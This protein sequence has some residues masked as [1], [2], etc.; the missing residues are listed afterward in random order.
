MQ[1]TTIQGVVENGQIKLSEAIEIP[2]ETIVYVVVPTV[3]PRRVARV[4]S[5][6]AVRPEK[7]ENLEREVIELADDE[8]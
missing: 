3:Q 5:P 4:M 7:L 1:V 6:R 2:D 8:I